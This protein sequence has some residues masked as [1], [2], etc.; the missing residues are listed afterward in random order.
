MRER[1][2]ELVE[3]L[4]LDLGARPMERAPVALGVVPTPPERM[5]VTRGRHGTAW[6]EHRGQPV[7]AARELFALLHASRSPLQEN[8]HTLIV[9]RAMRTLSH[10]LETSG[11]VNIVDLGP[12]FGFTT[13]LRA[14]RHPDAAGVIVAHNHPSGRAKPSD[15]DRRFTVSIAVQLHLAGGPPLVGHMVIDDETATHMAVE[16]RPK[17]GSEAE[18]AAA[19]QRYRAAR[20]TATR[21]RLHREAGRLLDIWITEHAVAVP[22]P[23]GTERDWT[24]VRGPRPRQV[25]FE[26]GKKG[27][28]P[29]TVAELLQQIRPPNARRIDV[30]YVDMAGHVVAVE[31]HTLDALTDRTRLGT[32]LPQRIRALA[33]SHAIIALDDPTQQVYRAVVNAA[34]GREDIQDILNFR[35]ALHTPPGQVVRAATNEGR[36]FSPL[37]GSGAAARAR[38]VYEPAGELPPAVPPRPVSAPAMPEPGD[39]RLSVLHNLSDDNL[40]AADKLGGFPAPSLAVLPE[41]VGL[42][43]FGNIT[44]IGKRE[45]ADPTQTPIY[46]AD[47]YTG[48][49]PGPEFKK[50]PTKRASQFFAQFGK[51]YFK[52][53]ML[54]EAWSHMVDHP[55]LRRAIE[56][57]RGS[58]LAIEAFLRE[59]GLWLPGWTPAAEIPGDWAEKRWQMQQALA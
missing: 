36:P 5:A 27:P 56:S 21:A 48:R 29:T 59:R 8:F 45:L 14:A 22:R 37:P 28:T 6:V 31:P 23:M 49:T 13:A 46:N 15:D 32:W 44:L 43:G 41:H 26:P 50:V 52:D 17:P 39:P 24:E 34:R 4:A 25:E 58:P 10:T 51:E 38:R 33:A 18:A 20:D 12:V 11:A 19:V 7:G 35:P 54:A 55:N 3:Q 53:T 16:V 42:E 40:I 2:T 47:A 1:A 30:A 57:V 9:D